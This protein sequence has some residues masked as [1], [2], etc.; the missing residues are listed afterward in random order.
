L[1]ITLVVGATRVRLHR[2]VLGDGFVLR[3]SGGK[4]VEVAEE[5]SAV[6]A[7]VEGARA[8]RREVRLREVEPHDVARAGDEAGHRVREV[9]AARILINRGR[10]G[11]GDAVGV[12]GVGV[13]NG[14][15]TAEV[16]VSQVRRSRRSA[17]VERHPATRPSAARAC[18]TGTCATGTCATGTCSAGT[19]AV[20][21]GQS[22]GRE[23]AASVTDVHDAVGDGRGLPMDRADRARV[24]PKLCAGRGHS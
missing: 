6:D 1:L 11:V 21:A 23:L 7:H 18:A 19:P 15:A 12:D 10:C 16:C 4:N 8:G 2:E 5:L 24:V 17:A 3:A 14:F 13:V 20:R 22:E 9:P